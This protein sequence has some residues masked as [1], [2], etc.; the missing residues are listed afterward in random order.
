[1]NTR[2]RN[3]FGRATQCTDLASQLLNIIGYDEEGP[4][5]YRH[6]VATETNR[7]AME[8]SYLCKY[9]R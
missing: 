8:L 9:Y 3:L 4:R 6:R 1:M 7:G 2:L 5:T